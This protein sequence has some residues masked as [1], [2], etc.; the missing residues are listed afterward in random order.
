MLC[1]REL[2]R[3]RAAGKEGWLTPV[4]GPQ[5]CIP[6]M[7]EVSWAGILWPGIACA[8]QDSGGTHVPTGVWARDLRCAVRG[9]GWCSLG[10]FLGV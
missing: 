9:G 5:V 3:F 10:M 7:A 4:A 2:L 6:H 8:I 1:A